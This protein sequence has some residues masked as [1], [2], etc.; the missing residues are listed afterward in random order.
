MESEASLRGYVSPKRQRRD[1]AR[2]AGLASGR[3]RRQFAQPQKRRVRQRELALKFPVKLIDRAE[4]DRR[5]FARRLA[6][7]LNPNERGTETLWQ[8]YLSC[9]RAYKAQGQGF[10]TTNGQRSAALH[11]AGRPRCARTIRRAHAALTEMGLLRRFHDRRGGARAGN[12]DR[13]RVQFAPS[14]VPPPSAAPTT[15]ASQ[16]CVGAHPGRDG[17]SHNQDCAGRAGRQRGPAPPGSTRPP[18]GGSGN[19]PA[20]PAGTTNGSDQEEEPPAG[21]VAR[22]EGDVEHA[23]RIWALRRRR[24]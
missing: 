19:P 16:S 13:L 14:F 8:E 6:A 9:A 24:P 5:D 12:R 15:T 4:F 3:K 1:R 22:C 18:F 21:L 7:G 2:K 20:E 10:L 11:K 23:R 17:T